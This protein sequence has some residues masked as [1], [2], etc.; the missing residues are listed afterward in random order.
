MIYLRH[1]SETEYNGCESYV[2]SA[3]D[4]DDTSWIPNQLALG[5]ETENKHK[6]TD[7]EIRRQILQTIE[8]EVRKHYIY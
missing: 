4:D 5:L 2:A 7:E 8:T 1:K 3:I 6:E